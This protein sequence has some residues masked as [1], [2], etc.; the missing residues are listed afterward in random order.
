MVVAGRVTL[1]DQSGV[2]LFVGGCRPWRRGSGSS[3]FASLGTSPPLELAQEKEANKN[4]LRPK[5]E[6]AANELGGRLLTNYE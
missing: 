6:L 2:N 4:D 5:N 3:V 1:P